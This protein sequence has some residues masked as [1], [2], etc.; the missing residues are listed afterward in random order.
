MYCILKIWTALFNIYAHL[1]NQHHHAVSHLSQLALVFTMNCLF[2][3]KGNQ[4]V[5][6]S[7]TTNPKTEIYWNS[8]K[9]IDKL[10][11]RHTETLYHI[12]ALSKVGGVITTRAVERLIILIALIARLII[13]IAR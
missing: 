10:L 1:P 12:T 6:W 11:H 7:M 13:L 3:T 8:L 4:F 2:T 5:L 9:F